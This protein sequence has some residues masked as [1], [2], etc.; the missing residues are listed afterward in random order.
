M[1]QAYQFALLDSASEANFITQSACN[2]LGLRQS[3]ASKLVTGLNE[4]ENKIYGICEVRIKSRCSS[5]QVNVQCLIVPKITKNLP[6]MKIDRSKLQLPSNIE[7]ADTDF[8][9]VGPIDMLI[10]AKYFF[11]LLEVG[12]TELGTDQLV[13]QNT[14]FG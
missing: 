1:V 7:L 6:S 2:K 10:G 14:K 4:I 8:Y 11:D 12:K 13:L 3:K 5:F 9:N